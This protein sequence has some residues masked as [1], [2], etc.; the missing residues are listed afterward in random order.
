MW[1]I[2]GQTWVDCVHNKCPTCCT[3]SLASIHIN[4]CTCLDTLFLPRKIQFYQQQACFISF[5]LPFSAPE[6][7]LGAGSLIT[8]NMRLVLVIDAAITA[9]KLSSLPNVTEVVNMGAASS[10]FSV[11]LMWVE[12][13]WKWK[14]APYAGGNT[15]RIQRNWE[16]VGGSTLCAYEWTG[17]RGWGERYTETLWVWLLHHWKENSVL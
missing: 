1:D 10:D 13:V 12:N 2:G 15:G 3:I 7:M 16:I 5:L 17:E 11:A 14:E 6:T 4:Y 9:Q 8:L